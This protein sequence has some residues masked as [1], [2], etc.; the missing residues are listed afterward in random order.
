MIYSLQSNSQQQSAAAVNGS[1]RIQQLLSPT[2]QAG[3]GE[4]EY[5]SSFFQCLYIGL[6]EKVQ[7]RLKVCATM[8]LVPDDLELRGLPVLIFW[9]SQPLCLKISMPG[10][11]SETSISQPPDQD[12]WCASNSGLQFIP[13]IVK[14]TTRKSHYTITQPSSGHA[15]LQ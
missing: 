9:N 7:P 10:S 2:R 8:P 14:L 13:D 5:K 12:H 6:Q 3:K 15:S 1:P 11:K 4:K